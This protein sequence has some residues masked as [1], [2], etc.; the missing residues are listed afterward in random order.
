MERR[1]WLAREFETHRAHLRGVAYRMLG[2]MIEAD[3]AVQ[4]AWLRLDRSDP[5]GSESMRGWLTVVIG[6][7]SLDVL[8][9]RRARR[10]TPA[11]SWLPEPVIGSFDRRGP[12]DESVMAD[13]IGIALLV[14]LEQLSPAERL[15]FVLHDV[16]GVSFDEV[17]HAVERTPAAAR[18][19]ASRARRR[20]RSSAP[21]PEANVTVQ[22]RVVDAFLAAARTGN[23]QALLEVLDPDVVF[24]IDLGPS[25]ADAQAPITGADA[26]ARELLTAGRRFAPLARPALVNGAAGA[27]AGHPGRR[28]VGVV[29]FSVVD[30]RIT[31]IDLIADPAKLRGLVVPLL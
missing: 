22:R 15:A 2:S 8:R 20:I 12:E 18:K 19:L 11:G 28:P 6:R 29:G 24:R 26:V 27:M 17:A 31:T 14:V 23:L 21:D 16:F 30:G 5:G 9:S 1:E 3:D 7:I 4:E 13:S 10:E 25:A